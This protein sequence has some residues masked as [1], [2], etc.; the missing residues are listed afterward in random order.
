MGWT[1]LLFYRKGAKREFNDGWGGGGGGGG[2]IVC[3]VK[4][5]TAIHVEDL[6]KF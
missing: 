5:H 6:N 2:V 4:N 3:F 1:G